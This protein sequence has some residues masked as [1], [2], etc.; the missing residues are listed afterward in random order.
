MQRAIVKEKELKQEQKIKKIEDT[1]KWSLK[2]V[3]K[4]RSK[5]KSE[6]KKRKQTVEDEQDKKPE[7]ETLGY[8]EINEGKIKGR[9]SFGEFARKLEREKPEVEDDD[10]HD[11]QPLKKRKVDGNNTGR[12]RK[13]KGPE[14]AF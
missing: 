13:L 11:K 5:S 6:G 1:S 14:K 12:D 2:A 8:S 4:S 7:T 10:E 3:F 9:R